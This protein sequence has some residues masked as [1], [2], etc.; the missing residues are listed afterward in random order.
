MHAVPVRRLSEIERNLVS[1]V[2]QREQLQLRALA[3]DTTNFFTHIAS[4]SRR[5]ILPER[6][7][8]KQGRHDLRQ[9]GLALIVNQG[10]HLPLVHSLYA[11]AR[12]DMRTSPS[13]SSRLESDYALCPGRRSR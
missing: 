8:N 11:G 1:D 6:V 13:S 5:T 9:M 2:V 12:S 4:A 7:H 10:S 3:Y